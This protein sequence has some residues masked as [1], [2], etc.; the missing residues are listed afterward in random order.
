MKS[1]SVIL[2]CI[3]TGATEAEPDKADEPSLDS[4]TMAAAAA[5]ASHSSAPPPGVKDIDLAVREDANYF[6]HY[7]PELYSNLKKLEVSAAVVDFRTCV[8]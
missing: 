3:F 5:G 6:Y 4:D 8:P 7:A 2:C 1:P